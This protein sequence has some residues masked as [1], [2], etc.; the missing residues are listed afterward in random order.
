FMEGIAIFVLTLPIIH[1]LIIDLGFD[2]VWFG[3]IMVLIMNL[4]L[5]T[6]PLGMSVYIIN[7]IVPE[8]PLQRIFVGVIPMIITIVS[9]IVLLVA[10]P[11]IVLFIRDYMN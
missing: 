9:F 4:G 3:I 10:F 6:P 8:V 1:P 11:E 2:G 7:G 5:L